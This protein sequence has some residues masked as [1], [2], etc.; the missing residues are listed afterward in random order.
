MKTPD[1]DKGAIDL[2][3]K[4]STEPF[5][6]LLRDV[7]LGEAED[8]AA[9]ILNPDSG[10]SLDEKDRLSRQRLFVLWV[11]D[12]PQQIVAQAERPRP[13]EPDHDPYAKPDVSRF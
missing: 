7:I 2:L 8:M 3:K 1:L 6:T 10:L 12:L 13:S 5:W 9:K 11:A 4:G